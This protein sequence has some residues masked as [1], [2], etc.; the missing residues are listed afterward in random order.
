MYEKIT[1]VS[2]TTTLEESKTSLLCII[3]VNTEA[4]LY[5]QNGLPQDT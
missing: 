3:L 1:A 2:N 5:K 4:N